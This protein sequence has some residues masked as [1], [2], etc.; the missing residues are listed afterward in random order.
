M[1]K[2]SYYD[3]YA[4]L[5]CMGTTGNMYE[6][7]NDTADIMENKYNTVGTVKKSIRKITDKEEK[8]I[9]LTHMHDR[10]LFWLRCRNL[11]KKWQCYTS[12]MVPMKRCSHTSVF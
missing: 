3:V 6:V 1:L 7:Y 5:L 4:K 10:W 11:S 8:L 2:V 9:P 12:L